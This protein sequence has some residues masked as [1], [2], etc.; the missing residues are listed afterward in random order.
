MKKLT[1]IVAI[2]VLFASFNI[3]YATSGACSYHGG[4]NCRVFSST[5]GNA[6]CNDGIESSVAY[7]DMDEC[8]QSNPSICTP[9]GTYT[10]MDNSQCAALQE[11]QFRNGGEYTPT[12]SSGALEYCQSQVIQYQAA[13]QAYQICL[14]SRSTYTPLPVTL[15]P[16]ASCKVQFGIHSIVSATTGYCSC[17]QGYLFDN[18]KQCIATPPVI[19]PPITP[20]VPTL[21]SPPASFSKQTL[22]NYCRGEHGANAIASSTDDNYCTCN[23]GYD[24]VPVT[25]KTVKKTLRPAMI[26][27]TSIATTSNEDIYKIASISNTSSTS[28][29][30]LSSSTTANILPNNNTSDSAP[31]VWYIRLFN[32]FR[33]IL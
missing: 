9:P 25:A 8:K 21:Q 19:T 33:K 16:S 7:S 4:V 6:I 15:S 26:K 29:T 5:D 32:I 3:T 2:F 20:V 14:N 18:N 31:E 11:Q 24:C 1:T 23:Q 17:E 10:Y 12:Q 30:T 27:N 22:D 13:E 28:T